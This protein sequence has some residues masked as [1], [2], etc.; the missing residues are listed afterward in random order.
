MIP[1]M[2]EEGQHKAYVRGNADLM[3]LYFLKG[4][5]NVS[6]NTVLTA[7]IDR[8]IISQCR[9]MDSSL[10]GTQTLSLVLKWE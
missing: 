7:K 9:T 2:G 10:E 5:K 1:G 4:F 8:K 6:V 3:Q